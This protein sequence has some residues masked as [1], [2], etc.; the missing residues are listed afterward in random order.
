VNVVATATVEKTPEVDRAAERE[1]AIR[2]V[3]EL[4][5]RIARAAPEAL[6][7]P[8]VA[9]EVGDWESQRAA[10]E[11]RVRQIGEA[12][13]ESSR[14]TEQAALE[15]EQRRVA[16][17]FKAAEKLEP[18]I[19]AAAQKYDQL[20]DQLVAAARDHKALVEQ[21]DELLRQAHPPDG[22]FNSRTPLYGAAL[23]RAALDSDGAE[24][25]SRLAPIFA[26]SN[27]AAAQRLYTK[28]DIDARTNTPS[29]TEQRGE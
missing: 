12:D 25:S 22:A 18:R 23:I 28:Q 7:D 6:S 3:Q 14:R 1:D 13:A 19:D 8:A 16:G 20:C 26:E 5:A 21:Q 2:Q 9:A 10:A 24:P 11:R 29:L 17:L 15:G 4:A 27:G